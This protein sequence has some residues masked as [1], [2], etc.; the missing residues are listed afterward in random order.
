MK[1]LKYFFC[2]LILLKKIKLSDSPHSSFFITEYTENPIR[3]DSA[4]TEDSNTTHKNT[5]LKKLSFNLCKVKCI[6]KN[7]IDERKDPKIKENEIM[8]WFT[9]KS[10]VAGVTE[11][12]FA[13]TKKNP[14]GIEPIEKINDSPL[15]KK[16]KNQL[17]DNQQ[18]DNI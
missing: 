13:I 7:Q 1:F 16:R 8:K 5:S 10:I 17:P 12:I 11:D 14:K 6:F 18:E 15:M 3:K 2:F 4:S 9:E